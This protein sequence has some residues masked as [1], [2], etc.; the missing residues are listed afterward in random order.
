[1]TLQSSPPRLRYSIASDTGQCQ[2][3]T[4]AGYVLSD[5]ETGLRLTLAE[6]VAAE[7]DEGDEGDEPQDDGGSDEDDDRTRDDVDPDQP[8]GTDR[9]D[10]DQ[11]LAAHADVSV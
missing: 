5:A 2:Q 3:L 10:T 7:H 6:Q 8:P 9:P 4:G 11:V 1:M